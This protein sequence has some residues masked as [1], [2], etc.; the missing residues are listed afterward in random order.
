MMELKRAGEAEWEEEITKV[1]PMAF[2]LA[3]GSYCMYPNP[4]LPDLKA[5]RITCPLRDQHISPAPERG[6]NASE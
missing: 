6:R 4:L 3:A 2:S 5:Y 1:C